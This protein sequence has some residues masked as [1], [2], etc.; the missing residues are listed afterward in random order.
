MSASSSSDGESWNTSDHYSLRV[1]LLSA[2]DLPPSLSPNVPLC[3]WFELGLVKGDQNEDD[4]DENLN[5]GGKRELMPKWSE[6]GGDEEEKE[7]DM[8]NA[9]SEA[10]Q[11]LKRLPPSAVRTSAFK[12]MTKVSFGLLVMSCVGAC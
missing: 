4:D 2:V 6:E 11:L 9:E 10:S 12:I 1:R 8:G 7:Q 5:V 3:P